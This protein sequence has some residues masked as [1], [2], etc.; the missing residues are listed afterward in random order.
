MIFTVAFYREGQHWTEPPVRKAL[1][2]FDWFADP[3]IWRDVR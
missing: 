1:L 3:Y 2:W